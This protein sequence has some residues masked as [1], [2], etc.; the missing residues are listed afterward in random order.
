MSPSRYL[1]TAGAVRAVSPPDGS[2]VPDPGAV[3]RAVLDRARAGDADAFRALYDAHAGRV[4]AL[5]LRLTGDAAE[6]REATQDAFVRMWRHLGDYRGEST[7]A[8]WVHRVAVTAVLARQ[9]SDARRL[10]RVRPAANP[11]ALGRAA[12]PA[13]L[14]ERLDLDAALAR[15]PEAA[16]TAFVLRELEGYPYDEIADLTGV[17][18]VALRSQVSRARHALAAML[19]L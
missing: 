11:D 4:Y 3:P 15:L 5:C 2:G 17:S 6:A 18:A 13:P 9:R 7:L 16:R 14:D 8:T 19:R 1:G 12:P 10:A